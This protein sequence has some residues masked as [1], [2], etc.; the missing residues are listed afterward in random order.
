MGWV[1]SIKMS[2][3]TCRLFGAAGPVIGGGDDDGDFASLIQSMIAKALDTNSVKDTCDCLGL[4]SDMGSRGQYFA[5]WGGVGDYIGSA[6]Q[7]DWLRDQIW[8]RF[9][10]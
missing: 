7:N 10:R 6:E 8:R 2:T 5:A 1:S 4:A 3:K 9:T